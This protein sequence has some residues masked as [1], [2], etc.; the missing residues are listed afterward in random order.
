M[1]ITE[2]A[3]S[4]TNGID[5]IHKDDAWLVVSSIVEHLSYQPGTFTYVLVYNGARH[6][7]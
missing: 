4:L 5:F 7:L 6:H 1:L 2:K 3:A